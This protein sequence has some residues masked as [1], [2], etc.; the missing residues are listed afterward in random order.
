METR[1]PAKESKAE[2]EAGDNSEPLA[3]VTLDMKQIQIQTKTQIK[4]FKVSPMRW[5]ILLGFC[6]FGLSSGFVS[7]QT[8]HTTKTILQTK[9][10]RI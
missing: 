3:S 4:S 8:R 2:L 6:V 5:S 10:D 7:R 9:V 1:Q